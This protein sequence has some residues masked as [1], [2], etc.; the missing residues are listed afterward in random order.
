MSFK[1]NNFENAILEI[2]KDQLGYEYYYGPEVERDYQLPL[3]EELLYGALVNIN[4]KLPQE[5]IDEA[6]LKLK[7]F[8]SGSLLE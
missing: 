2:F 7:G 1:E 4:D 5:A 6:L 3:H 8:D